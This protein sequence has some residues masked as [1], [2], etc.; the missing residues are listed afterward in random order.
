VIF[1]ASILE[2][3]R[4]EAALAAAIQFELLWLKNK[5]D[6][7][8]GIGTEDEKRIAMMETRQQIKMA[9]AV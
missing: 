6:Y 2:S 3:D 1:D 4:V 5:R 8:V 7:Y 9:V